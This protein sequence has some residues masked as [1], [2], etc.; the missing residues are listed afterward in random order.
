MAITVGPPVEV[1]SVTGQEIAVDPASRVI[2]TG[3]DARQN[4]AYVEEQSSAFDPDFRP[5]TKG[6][7]DPA[8]SENA[9]EQD[10]LNFW[11]GKRPLN[12][13]EIDHLQD[14]YIRNNDE[15]LAKLFNYRMTGDTSELSPQQME[16]LGLTQESDGSERFST[17]KS[18]GYDDFSP[19]Q[20]QEIDNFILT[21]DAQPDPQLAQQVVSADI[22]NSDAAVVVK[23]LSEQFFSGQLSLQE[24]YFK[25]GT[26]G[27]SQQRLYKAF[28][29]LNNKLQR[30]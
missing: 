20:T 22:G 17:D 6:L 21:S 9:S 23:H 16:D 10:L 26:S 28:A 14:Q 24:A 19:E 3:T 1:D 29:A 8:F 15:E 7:T 11:N 2:Q 30:R 13:A 25:A 27:I 5:T 18:F 4:T 12:E